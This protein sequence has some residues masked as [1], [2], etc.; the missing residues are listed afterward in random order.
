[1]AH[2]DLNE[3]LNFLIPFAQKMLE[4]HGEFFPFAATMNMNGKLAAEAVYEGSEHHASQIIINL[5]INRFKEKA[6]AGTL[7]AF[8]ICFDAIIMPPGQSQKENAICVSL[9]HSNSES[10]N[11]YLPYKKK[12]FGKISYGKLFAAQGEKRD[13][14]LFSILFGTS[15]RL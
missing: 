9:Q 2:P 7:K 10:I 4:E 14:A 8:G 11:V 1:M 15:Q 13:A 12:R 6:K 3:I 5:L